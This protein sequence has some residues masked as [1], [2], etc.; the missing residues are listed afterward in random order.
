MSVARRWPVHPA[1]APGEALSSWLRRIAS[2]YGADLDDLVS[3]LGYWP[4]GAADLD[5]CPPD[6]FAREL[7]GRTGVDVQHI[8]RMSLSGWSPW[9][10]D[11]G[12]PGP[13]TFTTYT[14]Q[15]SVLLEVTP[16]N[17]CGCFR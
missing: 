15:F 5:M 11:Q 1:P 14:Q 16:T 4:G 12:E 2:R 3:D 7:S 10:I 6:G 17:C 8:Q 13:D 9:L